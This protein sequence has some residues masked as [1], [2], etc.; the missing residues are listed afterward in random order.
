MK[1]RA[2]IHGLMEYRLDITTHYDEPFINWYDR[3]RSIAVR[4]LGNN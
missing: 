4:L 3:G 2:F 1:L